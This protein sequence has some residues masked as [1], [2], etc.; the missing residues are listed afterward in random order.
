MSEVRKDDIITP[1]PNIVAEVVREVVGELVAS[2]NA[3]Q[4]R[5]LKRLTQRAA[6]N[7]WTQ[8]ELARRINDVVGLDD[9]SRNAV[10]A[11]RLRLVRD[12]VPRGV[13]RT[14]ARNYANELRRERAASIARTEVAN[15][16]ATARRRTWI[17]ARDDGLIPNYAVRIW[18]T[19]KDEKTCG[20][21]GPM[22]GQ[23]ASLTGTFMNGVPGVPAHPNCRC[24]EELVLGQDVIGKEDPRDADSDGW[25][26]EGKPTERLARV[27]NYDK[28]LGATWRDHKKQQEA[29]AHF[30]SLPGHAKVAVY[31][32][33]TR[34][35]AEALLSGDVIGEG[36]NRDRK[37]GSATTHGLYVAPTWADADM[38][39]TPRTDDVVLKIWT[40]KDQLAPSGEARDGQGPYSVGRAL[41]HS[42][43]GAILIPGAKI[44]RIEVVSATPVAK[45]HSILG[46]RNRERQTS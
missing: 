1:D 29:I 14:T 45:A 9:R 40:T 8:E 23:R 35:H 13:A 34:E 12:G 25:I 46:R 10:E 37:H 28:F 31:H 5:S 22:N 16:L 27:Y 33:T 42:S 17:A 26:D 15:V 6:D 43:A 20:V 30:D 41:M 38:Y 44:D 36:K 21:C 11:M 32:G 2:L 24:T 39:T 18:R 3:Q 7:E 19:H 4:K